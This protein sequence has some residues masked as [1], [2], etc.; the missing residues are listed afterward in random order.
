MEM[1]SRNRANRH[2]MLLQRVRRRK[3]AFHSV[4]ADRL[5]VVAGY[6]NYPGIVLGLAKYG[7]YHVIV[8]LRPV[9]SATHGAYVDDIAYQIEVFGLY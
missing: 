4:V 3:G 8:A 7:A 6:V 9:Q 5:V 1:S 2:R